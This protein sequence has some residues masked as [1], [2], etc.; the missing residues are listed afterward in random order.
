MKY[1]A[2]R[3]KIYREEGWKEIS[4]ERKKKFKEKVNE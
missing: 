2:P 1:N 3:K 4:D